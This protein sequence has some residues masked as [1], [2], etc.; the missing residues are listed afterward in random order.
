MPDPANWDCC[1]RNRITARARFTSSGSRKREEVEAA[2]CILAKIRSQRQGFDLTPNQLIELK[3]KHV[4]ERT[5]RAL[6]ALPAGP[7]SS[8]PRSSAAPPVPL[9][10]I[11]T[12]AA[13][14]IPVNETHR[15]VPVQ[16]TRWTDPQEGAFAVSIPRGWSVNGAPSA[17]DTR[18]SVLVVSPDQQIRI[19]LAQV[20]HDIGSFR[21]FLPLFQRQVPSI[22]GACSQTAV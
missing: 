2:G 16:W 22:Q 11:A 19:T 18:K 8:T 12:P 7:Q 1:R 10:S 13:P 3:Q 14:V 9:A 15:R 5:I 21:D 17:T 4:G 20:R 6:V